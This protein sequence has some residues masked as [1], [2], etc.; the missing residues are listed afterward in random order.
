[1]ADVDIWQ[2]EAGSLTGHGP[3]ASPLVV[4]DIQNKENSV[5][6]NLH[7]YSSTTYKQ[8]FFTVLHGESHDLL[9]RRMLLG[10]T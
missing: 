3:I 6:T 7:L 5:I 8:C 1:M 2:D 10:H 9:P 4:P